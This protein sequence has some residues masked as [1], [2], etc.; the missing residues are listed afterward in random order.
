MDGFIPTFEENETERIK[1]LDFLLQKFPQ[2][3]T[4]LY[5]I[6]PKGNDSIYDL[7]IQTYYGKG[8][9]MKKWMDLDLK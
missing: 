9:C 5:A 4:L 6:N 7:D 8:F 3:H 1:L 2:I